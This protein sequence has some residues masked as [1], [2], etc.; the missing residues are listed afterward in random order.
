MLESYKLLLLKSADFLK[1]IT[2]LPWN[3]NIFLRV[4]EVTIVNFL[5]DFWGSHHV[6]RIIEVN[7]LEDN[8]GDID[9]HMKKL[10]QLISYHYKDFILP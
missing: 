3:S 1:T 7:A 5:F 6:P 4:H 10:S 8:L 9:C 2:C